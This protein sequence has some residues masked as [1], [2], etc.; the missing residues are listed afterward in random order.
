MGST[1]FSGRTKV[2]NEEGG[3][4]EEEDGGRRPLINAPK[5]AEGFGNCPV[6][7]SPSKSEIEG[8]L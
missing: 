1:G 5:M 6:G 7:M 4:K 3:G 8:G 2:G